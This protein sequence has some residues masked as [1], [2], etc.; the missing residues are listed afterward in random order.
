MMAQMA[1]IQA[2]HIDLL[3]QPVM[4]QVAGHGLGNS[5]MAA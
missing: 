4:W 5:L 1:D 3:L 2:F